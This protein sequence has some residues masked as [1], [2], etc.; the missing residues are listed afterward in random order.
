[1]CDRVYG[2][3]CRTIHKVIIS[4]IKFDYK[5][6]YYL[7]GNFI[8]KMAFNAQHDGLIHDAK[9]DYYAKRLATCSGDGSINIFEVRESEPPTKLSSI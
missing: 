1:M 4:L 9:F 7:T 8:S 2:R 3:G 5:L 6:P